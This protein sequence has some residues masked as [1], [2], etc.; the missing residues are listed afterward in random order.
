ML[1]IEPVFE[2]IGRT[3][4][5]EDPTSVEV[6]TTLEAIPVLP[7]PS[8]ETERNL[9]GEP[10]SNIFSVESVTNAPHG[11]NT[12]LSH[13]FEP[14]GS[15]S[16]PQHIRRP[17]DWLKSRAGSI[18]DSFDLDDS[19]YDPSRPTCL[20]SI[21]HSQNIRDPVQHYFGCL[22]LTMKDEYLSKLPTSLLDRIRSEE[23]RN[24]NQLKLLAQQLK[25]GNDAIM[26]LRWSRAQYL[27]R[28]KRKGLELTN[29][30]RGP[31]LEGTGFDRVSKVKGDALL[32][33]L[34]LRSD[35]VIFKNSA[36]CDDSRLEGKF[37]DQYLPLTDILGLGKYSPLAEKSKEGMIRYFHLPANNM[38]WVEVRRS[39]SIFEVPISNVDYELRKQ[40]P[41]TIGKKQRTNRTN[42]HLNIIHSRV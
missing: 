8:D 32:D 35:V 20:S 34:H 19:T 10:F 7:R 4:N 12:D 25:E 21:E 13:E 42:D 37:P 18:A 3:L 9:R 36:P 28:A 16:Q 22:R 41:V 40:Y 31:N 27:N 14:S 24:Y 26:E 29:F 15:Q 39:N 23:R 33:M 2:D 1:P 6:F 38:S 30:D 17:N 5:I 11:K